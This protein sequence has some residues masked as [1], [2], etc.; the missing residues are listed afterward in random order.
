MESATDIL[1]MIIGLGVVILGM[2]VIAKLI[3]RIPKFQHM[4]GDQ[5]A[6][7]MKVKSSLLLDTRHR[8]VIVDIDGAEK[9]FLLSPESAQEVKL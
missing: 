9:V 5:A 2:L 6:Q 7:R 4:I 8:L 1:T 3:Q